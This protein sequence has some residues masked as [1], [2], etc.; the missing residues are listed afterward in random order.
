MLNA[1][2]GINGLSD[3][4]MHIIEDFPKLIIRYFYVI[5]ELIHFVS[6]G[7]VF[8]PPSIACTR[9]G[10]NHNKTFICTWFF[11]ISSSRIV[12]LVTGLFHTGFLPA[13]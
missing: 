1:P 5:I 11:L 7:S 3:A 2:V 10:G 6:E 13:G 9:V 12:N 8:L 4:A